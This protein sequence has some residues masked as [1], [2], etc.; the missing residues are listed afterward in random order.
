MLLTFVTSNRQAFLTAAVGLYLV[1]ALLLHLKQHRAGAGVLMSGILVHSFFLA[2][3]G[4]FF[5][6]FIAQP[7]YEGPY[8]LPWCLALVAVYQ[9]MCNREEQVFLIWLAALSALLS[10][11]YAAGMTPPAPPKLS[12]FAI[13]FFLTENMGHSLFYSGA[14]LAGLG[15]ARRSSEA[16]FHSLIVWGF[17]F[18]SISQ[19][20]GAW[21]CFLGWGNTFRWSSRHMSSAGIWL[22]YAAYM[23]LRFIQ[24]F[25]VAKRAWFAVGAAALTLTVT[26]SGYLHEMKL[27]RLG[28]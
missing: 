18:Y 10:M 24:S 11:F 12:G 28:G 23:H 22:V 5:D 2:S 8:L 15:L 3:R 17:L 1:A 26:M 7:I 6:E 16:T 9:G 14:V 25:S 21:W 20:V 13:G 27:P 4:F 19:V